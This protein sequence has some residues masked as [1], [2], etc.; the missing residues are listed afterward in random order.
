[1]FLK[2]G[3]QRDIIPLAGLD[4]NAN[5]LSKSGEAEIKVLVELFQKL[6]ESRGRAS[7]RS[8]Q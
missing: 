7:G 8:P 3:F 6:A 4:S 1:V 5:N 2:A